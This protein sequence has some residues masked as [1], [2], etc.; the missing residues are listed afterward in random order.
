MK[1]IKSMNGYDNL[2][3]PRTRRELESE[4]ENTKQLLSHA[5]ARALELGAKQVASEVSG[6]KCDFMERL[7]FEIDLF[8]D[9]LCVLRYELKAMQR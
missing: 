6:L 8:R 1:G 9:R 7:G 2:Q 4:I 5:K 3:N